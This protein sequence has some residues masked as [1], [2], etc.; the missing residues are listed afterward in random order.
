MP[1]RFVD[2]RTGECLHPYSNPGDCPYNFPDECP[3]G[4]YKLRRVVS[5]PSLW[6]QAVFVIGLS[7]LILFYFSGQLY[8]YSYSLYHSD[9]TIIQWLY[10]ILAWIIAILIDLVISTIVVLLFE[11]LIIYGVNKQA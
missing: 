1:C 10:G 9:N 3:Y 11:G 6:V 7:I 5:M 8:S 2:Q 4:E